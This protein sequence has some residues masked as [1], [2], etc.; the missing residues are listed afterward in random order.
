M[1]SHRCVCMG[2]VQLSSTHFERVLL[3]PSVTENPCQETPYWAVVEVQMR[4]GSV[5]WG[6]DHWKPRG[7]GEGKSC[8]RLTDVSFRCFTHRYFGYHFD[9]GIRKSDACDL[10]DRI[11][12]TWYAG[13]ARH[14]ESAGPGNPR[15]EMPDALWLK[16]RVLVI[17][18]NYWI[19][20][21]GSRAQGICFLQ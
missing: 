18:Q 17:S 10:I 12:K 3:S 6:C 4:K 8:K 2:R 13:Q 21:L 14:W 16:H 5:W 19:R 1:G 15:V 7:Q 9:T 20:V 11:R